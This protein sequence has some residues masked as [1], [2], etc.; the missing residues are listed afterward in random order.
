[1]N[2]TKRTG[3]GAYD[4]LYPNGIVTVGKDN[5]MF[6]IRL[7]AAAKKEKQLIDQKE[8]DFRSVRIG[9]ME[10]DELY[11]FSWNAFGKTIKLTWSRTDSKGLY[12]QV[13]VPDGITILAELYICL[14]YTSD[15]ADE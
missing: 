5:E 6:G 4:A 7:L 11:E 14:L 8:F 15:A 3:Y 2:Q 13:E 12:G 1:M 10:P 9:R